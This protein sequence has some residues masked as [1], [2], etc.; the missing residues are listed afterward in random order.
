ML[1]LVLMAALV[2]RRMHMARRDTLG[3]AR[4][5]TGEVPDRRVLVLPR[6]V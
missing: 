1:R 2:R 5:S 4:Q 3:V 6:N